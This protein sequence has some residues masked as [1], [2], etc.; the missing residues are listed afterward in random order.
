MS[1]DQLARQ[2]ADRLEETFTDLE[3]N[4]VSV[5]GVGWG[6]GDGRGV[7]RLTVDDVARIC[8]RVARDASVEDHERLR[9]AAATVERDMSTRDY[10]PPTQEDAR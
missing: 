7:I 4:H 5:L 2:M 8:A 9:D 3:R 10:W 1:S 6:L